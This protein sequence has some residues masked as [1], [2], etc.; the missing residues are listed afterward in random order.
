MFYSEYK[1]I[2]DKLLESLAKRAYHRL[3]N[4]SKDPVPLELISE[5]SNRIDS[6]LRHTLEVYENSLNQKRKN[7]T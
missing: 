1:H 2:T 5:K 7:M 4:H 3:L 6:Y